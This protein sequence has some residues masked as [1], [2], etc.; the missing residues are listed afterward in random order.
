MKNDS[1]NAKTGTIIVV[2][3]IAVIIVAAALVLSMA[4]P[5]APQVQQE[6]LT[7]AMGTPEPSLLTL[8]AEDQGYF[9][10]H[11]LNVT[12][13]M[14]PAGAYAVKELL[15]GNAD[16][17][18]AAE[19][20]GVANSYQNP[21]LRIITTTAKIDNL[22]LI[23]R[24]DRGITRPSD[25]AGKTIAVTKGTMAE[26]FLGRY[27]TLNGMDIQNI[28]VLY[29][30]PDDVVKSVV[31]GESDAAI[32][33]DPTASR[34]EEQLGGNSTTWNAQSGQF[35]Y[36]AT[37]ARADVIRDRPDM[38]RKYVRALDDAEMFLSTQSPEEKETIRQRLNI[39]DD[40]PGRYWDEYHFGL[41][42]DQVLI[43]T[44]EDE[45]RWM[46]EQ[47]MTGGIPSPSYLAMIDQD[48]M[49]EIKPQAVTII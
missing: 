2:G 4:P 15:A 49:R 30:A 39:T 37:Y 8:V 9:K 6:P 44:M 29:R 31:S 45:A 7:I 14:Y 38:I 17:A 12:I 13:R 33:W 24:C 26:F 3:I 48:A 5:P 47:N 18:S 20:V 28:T 43:L 21:D 42:L 27:L 11:G 25:L 41:S 40:P 35:Y 32:M 34:I 36:W 22:F 23:V 16:L 1:P 10:E 46:A 19:F